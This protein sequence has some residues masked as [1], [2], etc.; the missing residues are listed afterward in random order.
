[1]LNMAGAAN[2]PHGPLR[3]ATYGPLD[4]AG[5]NTKQISTTGRTRAAHQDDRDG[6]DREQ[7]RRPHHLITP[8]SQP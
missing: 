3:G 6:E 4:S 8:R 5:R 1:M 2:S 7:G